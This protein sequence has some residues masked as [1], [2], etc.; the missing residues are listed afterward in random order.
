[1]ENTKDLS[2][3]LEG[4]SLLLIGATGSGKS[5][6][7]ASAPTPGFLID[8][9]DEALSYRGKDFDYIKIS[10]DKKGTNTLNNILIQLKHGKQPDPNVKGRTAILELPDKEYKTYVLD[11]STALADAAMQYALSVES[12]TGPGGSPIWNVHYP[13]V[14]N[15]MAGTIRNF[16]DLPGNR[17][18]CCHIEMFRDEVLGKIFFR[19]MIG[20]KLVTKLPTMFD[21]VLYAQTK[22][23]SGKGLQYL[24]QTINKGFYEARSRI[25]GRERRLPD[26]I[27]NDWA[28]LIGGMK[29][30][31]TK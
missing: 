24:L 22:N 13:I 15:Y 4:F 18:V 26:F 8:V 25:S 27:P 19:P 2:N 30:A 10:K 31:S 17:I 16:L 7:A 14:T 23:V 9:G 5:T 11:N 28:S 20:G 29:N 1:M 21:E 3:K 6:M 12:G